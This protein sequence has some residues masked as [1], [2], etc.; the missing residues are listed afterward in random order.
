MPSQKYKSLFARSQL[1]LIVILLCLGI[2]F[3][4]ANLGDKIFWVDEVATAVRVSGYTIGQVI[5]DLQAKNIVDRDVLD[6]YQQLNHTRTFNDSL[7]GL[8]QSPEHAPLYFLLTRFWL[9]TWGSS[10]VTLRSLSAFLSL[11]IFPSLYWLCQELFRKNSVGW[12]SVML[13]SVSP[14]YVAYAQEARP[15]SL[16]TISILVMS[17]SLVRAIK[18][19]NWQTWSLYGLSLIFS[20]YTSLF[21]LFIAVA[22]GIYLLLI[23]NKIK[24]QILRNYLITSAIALLAFA[25]WLQIIVGNLALVE[26]NTSWMRSTLSISNILA[27]WIGTI[28][29]IFGDLPLSTEVNPIKMAIV[30]IGTIFLLIGL[31]L[32]FSRWHKFNRRLQQVIIGLGIIV[33]LA[34]IVIFIENTSLIEYILRDY[35]ALIGAVVALCI[36][37]L[38]AYS[39]YFLT[40]KTRR[41][42]WLF[43]I[44]LMIAVPLPLILADIIN[45]GQ[46]SATPRYL[47]PLQL[48][49][50]IAVAYTLAS[51]LESHRFKYNNQTKIWRSIVAAFLTLG[52]FSCTRN[53][54]L[55]P[56]Y[57]KG[58]NL[59]NLPIANLINR[60]RSPLVLV[61][62]DD[63][64][65]IL[66]LAHSLSFQVKF[67]LIKPQEKLSDHFD[68][69]STV[70]I[71]KPSSELIKQL[72]SNPEISLQQVYQPHLFSS[73]EIALEL[74]QIDSKKDN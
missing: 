31:C 67:K 25:P 53:L 45:R 9:Q 57:Q 6:R 11:L 39:L 22:Q 59:H 13:M 49:I 74:W 60:A 21:S 37:S 54:N 19:N 46:S 73:D 24:L 26:D 62:P 35:V 55:S 56:L 33:I 17:A 30:L 44:S 18:H 15:Y 20:F 40:S 43:I 52:I 3:R 2:F 42:R 34:I 29:L 50:Q 71:L 41:D 12:M 36:L 58:R 51:K 68:Y 72:K 63:T 48:G 66:S 16:W 32:L 10:I 61:E 5:E 47:I 1:L 64:M 70:F 8:K 65:D 23:S 4:F 38:S 7:T 69:F 27:V 28:L 14:F